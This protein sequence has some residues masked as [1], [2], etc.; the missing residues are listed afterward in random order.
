MPRENWPGCPYHRADMFAKPPSTASI[1]GERPAWLPE[2]DAP[3]V[4]FRVVGESERHEAPQGRTFTLGTAATHDIVL[5]DQTVSSSHCL[6]EWRGH[7]LWIQDTRSKNGT[8]VNGVKTERSRVIDGTVLVV[9]K[10]TM[11]AFAESSR[12]RKSRD[13]VL[14]G[15]DPNFRIAVDVAIAAAMR[16]EAVVIVGE[17]GSGRSALARAIHEVA[18]GPHLPFVHVKA[19]R[20]LEDAVAKTALGTVFVDGLDTEGAERRDAL[21]AIRSARL[22]HGGMTGS[23]HLIVGTAQS[24]ATELEHAVVVELP[25]L[26]ERGEDVLLLVDAFVKEHFGPDADREVFPVDV[27]VALRRYPW[28]ENV[29]ELKEA[30][31]RLSLIVK[32]G[33]IEA[34]AQSVGRTKGAFADW[35][36]R[37]GIPPG[38]G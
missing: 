2:S 37:R 38:R 24:L 21:H 14:E 20:A 5:T 18:V 27:L 11:I 26:R 16:G 32:H 6:F 19:E 25:A 3:V 34:A 9:G 30:V 8:Y 13:E 10:T 1:G 22:A 33:T 36:Y 35:L 7:D 15:R 29:A 12:H 4:G 28:P 31:R 17:A 23:V